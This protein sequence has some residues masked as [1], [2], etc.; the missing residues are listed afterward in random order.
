MPY[1]HPVA[2]Q[3]ENEKARRKEGESE[4]RQHCKEK[5]MADQ[6]MHIKKS[7]QLNKTKMLMARPEGR[8]L[9]EVTQSTNK[10][11]YSR[12]ERQRHTLARWVSMQDSQQR[13]VVNQLHTKYTTSSSK[14]RK[15]S[16]G[17][18]E[19]ALP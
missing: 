17:T 15:T 5:N 12:L 14:M 6:W 7:F 16:L 1:V 19:E 10:G 13:A 11:T 18:L 4:E 9:E 2:Q 8:E 3:N